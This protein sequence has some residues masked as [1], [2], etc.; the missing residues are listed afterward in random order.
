MRR[1]QGLQ[2]VLL[3][4][5]MVSWRFVA[6]LHFNIVWV[7]MR[8]IPGNLTRDWTRYL[9]VA[10]I[11]MLCGLQS[12]NICFNITRRRQ[13][14]NGDNDAVE[15]EA[16]WFNGIM[17]FRMLDLRQLTVIASDDVQILRK[18]NPDP[19]TV[20]I[21]NVRFTAIEKRGIANR[22]VGRLTD[23]QGAANFQAEG[24]TR[25]AANEAIPYM[26]RAAVR[27]EKRHKGDAEQEATKVLE[28]LFD[29]AVQT[30]GG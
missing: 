5:R 2:A 28:E 15:A 7:N 16:G 11:Q 25:H 23:P 22:I 3:P 26:K 4:R 24:A 18:F 20:S 9:K 13:A 27:V 29:T 14:I 17:R 21:Q 6:H 8:Y 19:S 12:L 30:R 10:H 1:W